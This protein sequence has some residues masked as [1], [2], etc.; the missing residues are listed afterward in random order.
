MQLARTDF[1]DVS[2]DLQFKSYKPFRKPGDTLL[3]INV[4]S[5][6]P[7]YIKKEI[8]KMIS[9]ISS[10]SSGPKE[11]DIALKTSGYKREYRISENRSKTKKL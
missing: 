4:R 9:D 1:L 7:M 5:N 8:F 3:Y 10:I 2:F 11:F 6:H